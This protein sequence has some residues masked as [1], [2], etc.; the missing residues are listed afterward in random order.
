MA[1]IQLLDN[2]WYEVGA[3]AHEGQFKGGGLTEI[4]ES[5]TQ[6]GVK[7]VVAGAITITQ[8]VPLVHGTPASGNSWF[9]RNNGPMT[10]TYS[11]IEI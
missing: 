8:R 1:A 9:V 10:A 7:E 5:A 6:P 3:F 2:V 4:I 11:Y